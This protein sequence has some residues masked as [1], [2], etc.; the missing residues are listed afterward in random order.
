MKNWQNAMSDLNL[1]FL[2]CQSDI[3][4]PFNFYLYDINKRKSILI[5]MNVDNPQVIEKTFLSVQIYRSL[6]KRFDFIIDLSAD[7]YIGAEYGFSIKT[8]KFT[9]L[10]DQTSGN[11][12]SYKLF[13]ERSDFELGW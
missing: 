13:Y 10:F 11:E 2:L 5:T 7:A 1:D 6:D 9:K 4:N 3:R 8:K 12:T